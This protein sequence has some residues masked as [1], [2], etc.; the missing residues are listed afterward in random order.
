MKKRLS[1]GLLIA[2]GALFGVGVLSLY[3]PTWRL[4]DRKVYDL[5]YAFQFTGN[6][7]PVLNDRIVIVDIDDKSLKALGRYQNW[8]RAYYGRVIDY[9]GDAA[10]VG[11]DVFFGEPDT[12]PFAARQYY[13]KPNF[14][15]LLYAAL[16][17]NRRVVMVSSMGEK[18]IF[19]DYA[20][21]G[22]GDILADKFDGIVR[23]GY[24]SFIGEKTFAA[25]IAGMVR[26]DLPQNPFLIRF[27]KTGSF[28]R[29]SFIDV[30]EARVPREFFSGKIVLVGGTAA[31]L[32]DYH[33]VPF[34]R[35][36][37]GIEL[38]ANLVNNFTESIKINEI[39]YLYGLIITLLLT[40]VIAFLTLIGKA[41]I[42]IP[43]TILVY[44]LFIAASFILFSQFREMGVIRPYYTFTLGLIA[45][46]VY[47]YRVEEK[48]KRKIKGIFSRYYSR[49]LLDMVLET[50]P[51]LGGEKVSCT[52]IFAD[53][54]N[55]TPFVEKN[56]PEEVAKRLNNLLTEMVEV[57]FHYQGRIDKY[58]GDCIMAVFGSPIHLKNHAA[59]ACR[60]A[61]DMVKMAAE[62]GFKIGVGMNSGEVISGNFGSPM[63]MEFTVIGDNVNLASRLEGATKDLVVSIV[64]SESTY[65]MA[66]REKPSDLVFRPLG[67]VKVKGKEEEI[68]VYE[69]S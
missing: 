7:A 15:S 68:N 62:C 34:N 43:A 26:A 38:Q 11:L 6:A 33:A 35:H 1:A 23:T 13:Q 67:K 46:L 66:S 19:A 5:K 48:E 36:F 40:F 63:R 10:V 9:L 50:P 22:T 41:R 32:F 39:P 59:N 3:Q 42:Y 64:I 56:A 14:D 45:T 69:V 52:V 28:R 24:Y 2:F 30:Y 21:F 29:I 4:F 12:L 20:R 44:L 60:A 47:R 65:Q 25:V 18:P 55:F 54:R 31:G 27:S 49:E 58:I 57:V 16:G 17:R 61:R 37:P 8:P 51:V 53:I